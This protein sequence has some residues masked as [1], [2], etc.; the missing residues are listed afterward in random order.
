VPHSLKVPLGCELVATFGRSDL[1]QSL[2]LSKDGLDGR[3]ACPDEAVL[4]PRYAHEKAELPDAAIGELSRFHETFR[5]Y[6]HGVDDTTATLPAGW[7][8]RLIAVH[9]ENTAGRRDG[10]SSASHAECAS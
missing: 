2:I 8:Q 5:Y 1:R 9:N 7:E 10:A 4:Y 6:A 3:L